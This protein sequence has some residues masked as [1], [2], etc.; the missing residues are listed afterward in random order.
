[1]EGNALLR[2]LKN[3]GREGKGFKQRDGSETSA[4]EIEGKERGN[5]GISQA[6]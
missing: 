3:V 5:E 2:D 1:M 6:D 4:R